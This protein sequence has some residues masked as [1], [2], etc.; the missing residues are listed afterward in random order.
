MA[1]YE[2]LN[3]NGNEFLIGFNIRTNTKFKEFL[4]EK[5]FESAKIYVC[6]GV[7]KKFKIKKN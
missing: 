5:T 4:C 7:Q 1:S 2:L 3:R 6:K